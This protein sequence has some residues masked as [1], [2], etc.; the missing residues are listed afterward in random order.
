MYDGYL[1]FRFVYEQFATG[2][3]KLILMKLYVITSFWRDL[4]LQQ[5]P[6]K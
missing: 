5:Y 2:V 6:V 1:R 3:D 4:V